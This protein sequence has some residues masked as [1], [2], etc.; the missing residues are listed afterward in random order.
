MLEYF[1]KRLNLHITQTVLPKLKDKDEETFLKTFIEQWKNY[2][3]FVHFMRKIFSYLDRYHLKNTSSQSLAATALTIFKDNCFLQARDRLRTAI[4][5]QISR[6]RKNEW[7]DL[8]LL[9][10]AIYTFV[11]MGFI[12]GDI[13]KQDDDFIYKGDKNNDIIYGAQF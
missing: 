7:V 13:V 10:R 4:L 5:T 6:D 12:N 11:E 9:K 8:D 2:T 1:K 3:I